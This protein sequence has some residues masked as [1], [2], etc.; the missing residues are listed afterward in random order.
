MS[1]LPSNPTD[2]QGIV[3]PPIPPWLA[4]D[5]ERPWRVAAHH[6]LRAKDGNASM[7]AV[8]SQLSHDMKPLTHLTISSRLDISHLL[9]ASLGWSER[10]H[11]FSD[12]RFPTVEYLRASGMYDKGRE[13]FGN[14]I[15]NRFH[16]H[17][18]EWLTLLHRDT[19]LE[20]DYDP[21]GNLI[22]IFDRVDKIWE[23]S[24]AWAEEIAI[25]EKK[26]VVP[27][28][29]QETAHFHNYNHYAHA[30]GF[31]WVYDFRKTLWGAL[32]NL[33]AWGS[34]STARHTPALDDIKKSVRPLPSSVRG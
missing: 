8:V 5:E 23:E 20:F 4:E 34:Y 27:I 31:E 26:A 9:V 14:P 25:E 17:Y 24:K 33:Y 10:I 1:A 12:N 11:R 2:Y 6:P 13:D 19:I 28:F 18:R 32:D 3:F 16:R 7:A 21:R 29:N 22:I 15:L 30:S